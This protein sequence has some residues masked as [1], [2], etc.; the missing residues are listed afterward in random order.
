ML[1]CCVPAIEMDK[2]ESIV[3]HPGGHYSI[4]SFGGS[5]E[6]IDVSLCVLENAMHEPGHLI[7]G[8]DLSAL[9]VCQCN[10]VDD[11]Y[12]LLFGESYEPK[13]PPIEFPDSLSIN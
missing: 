10:R 5:E 7:T 3:I 11:N 13:Y 8:I 12:S 6:I 2:D 9:A 4:V 1:K